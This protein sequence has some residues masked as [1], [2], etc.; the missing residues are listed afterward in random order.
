[1]LAPFILLGIL[2]VGSLGQEY[3]DV[4]TFVCKACDHV[5]EIIKRHL[6]SEEARQFV[7]EDL[8]ELCRLVPVPEIVEGCTAF[9]TH[10]LD[11]YVARL[12]KDMDAHQCCVAMKLCKE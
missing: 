1:M 3:G 9:I 11:A 10:D 5:M 4:S 6:T 12:G 7:E 8:V 2:V